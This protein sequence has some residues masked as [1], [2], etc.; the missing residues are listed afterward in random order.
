MR[1]P[2]QIKRAPRVDTRFEATLIDSDG[3]KHMSQANKVRA[4]F[5]NS[6]NLREAANKLEQRSAYR[7]IVEDALVA[8]EQ[9]SKLTDPIDQHVPIA[10]PPSER[11]WP[12]A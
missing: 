6:P 1:E 8:Q 5:W 9:H 4:S 12:T 7:A 2:G 11:N 3:G 10:V